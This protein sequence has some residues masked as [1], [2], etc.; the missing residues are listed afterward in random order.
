[1]KYKLM[2]V[3]MDGTLLNRDGVITPVTVAAI[4]EAVQSGLL[5][6]LS[7]GRPIMGVEDYLPLLSPG[8]PVITY[9]GAMIVRADT[10]EVLFEQPL[11]PADA[12]TILT[13]GR[14]LD[15]TMCIWSCN[16]LYCNV[17]NERVRAYQKISKR[18]PILFTDDAELAAQKIIKILYYDTPER[19]AEIQN[20]LK[21]VPLGE[22][23]YCTSQPIFLEFFSKQA[24]KALALERIGALYGIDRTEMIAVGDGHN[25]LSMIEYAGLGVAMANASPDVLRAAD[26]VTASNQDDGVAQVLRK[27]VL[28]EKQEKTVF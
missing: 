18:E 28:H 20:T 24:S 23:S 21:H 3:D 2:A 5:F 27:Y 4:R 25:D 1:M 22:T 10:R 13:L 14:A 9:N 6:T 11:S 15:T 16:R 12:M 7:T 19:L 26:A 17:I 8:A